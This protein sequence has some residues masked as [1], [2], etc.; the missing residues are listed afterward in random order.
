MHFNN[1][2]AVIVDEIEEIINITLY[3]QSVNLSVNAFVDFEQISIQVAQINSFNS[4]NYYDYVKSE[5]KINSY[6]KVN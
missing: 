1:T 5:H 2:R 3:R 6:P 4:E